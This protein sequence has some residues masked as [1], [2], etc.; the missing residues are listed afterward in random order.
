MPFSGPSDPELPDHIQKLSLAKRR[1]WVGAWNGSFRDCQ[2]EGAGDCEGRA[3]RIAN[4]AIKQRTSEVQTLIFNKADFTKGEAKDWASDH[5]YSSGSVEETDDSF[6]I[7][8]RAP[9]GCDEFRTIEL[10][11]GVKAVLCIKVGES[12]MSDSATPESVKVGIMD[13]GIWD[14]LDRQVSQ[15]AANYR[16]LGATGERGCANCQFFVAPNGC[17]V[18]ENYPEAIVPTGLSDLWR[19]RVLPG[20]EMMPIPVIVVNRGESA[21]KQTKREDGVDFPAEDFAVVPALDRPS[22]WMLRLTENKAGHLT[23]AQIGQA[24]TAL[25]PGGIKSQKVDLTDEQKNQAIRKISAA[26]RRVDADKEQKANLRE[27]LADVKALEPE[28][29]IHTSAGSPISRRLASAIKDV[30]S[31]V[32]NAARIGKLPD[33]QQPLPSSFKVIKDTK[34]QWRWVALVTN[35]FRDKDHPP[36]IFTEA[37]HK[38]FVSYLD[39]GGT[40]PALWLWH[41]PGTKFGQA[42]WADYTDGFLIQSGTIEAGKEAITERLSKMDNLGVSHGYH[43]LYDDAEKGEIGWYRSF[44]TSVLPAHRAANPWASIEFLKGESEKAMDKQKRDWLVSIL[45]E[46]AVKGIEADAKARSDNLKNLGIESKSDDGKTT[47]TIPTG[48]GPA[49]TGQPI[50]VDVKALAEA[51]ANSEGFKSLTTRLT[52]LEGTVTRLNQTDDA[53]V[54]AMFQAK[55]ADARNG[56]KGHVASQSSD[57]IVNKKDV[58]TAPGADWFGGVIAG[59]EQETGLKIG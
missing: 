54:A 7:R 49:A 25:Q 18:V 44:E 2:D 12:A 10:T 39:K 56:A 38:D 8:Q 31:A 53:K 26:I 45:G 19:A 36:E 43:F 16:S 58:P 17:T 13:M 14:V 47:A 40:M 50:Q 46:D 59:I 33:T 37:A 30:A 15:Q 55:S 29:I 42:D 20:S 27:R 3:F 24:I 5:E 57:N 6:R 1:Q 23:V 51:F 34:G 35:N 48:A 22:E 32:I 41:E 11:D 9:E 21:A 28:I 52:A 4:A